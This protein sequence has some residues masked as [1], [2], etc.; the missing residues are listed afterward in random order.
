MI[1]LWLVSFLCSFFVW[2]GRKDKFHGDP[3][4]LRMMK[5]LFFLFF[6]LGLSIWIEFVIDIM[7]V[8]KR[9]KK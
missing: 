7:I 9:M 2:I 8:I 1:K 4:M 3:D 6:I 5:N